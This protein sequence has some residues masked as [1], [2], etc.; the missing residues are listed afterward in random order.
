[1]KL[2]SVLPIISFVFLVNGVCV[3]D[4]RD[5]PIDVENAAHIEL[6]ISLNTGATAVTLGWSP[7]GVTLAVATEEKVLV[8]DARDWGGAAHELTTAQVISLIFSPDGQS[9]ATSSNFS[10]DG[11][12]IWDMQTGAQLVSFKDELP[13]MMGNVPAVAMSFS[14]DGKLLATQHYQEFRGIIYDPWVRL[15]DAHTGELLAKIDGGGTTITFNPDGQS[16]AATTRGTVRVWNLERILSSGPDDVLLEDLVL[17][18]NTILAFSD[19]SNQ[20]AYLRDGEIQIWDIATEQIINRPDIDKG[21]C[22]AKVPFPI[23]VNQ[24][25]TEQ[26]SVQLWD[27]CQNQLLTTLDN[28]TDVITGTAFNPDK[29]LLAT[30]SQDGTVRLWGLSC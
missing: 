23:V 27:G 14:P 13:N 29:T 28:Y 5:L 18:G 19:D 24:Y 30:T 1:M 6:L 8:Y 7:D 21:L 16:L 2:A 17:N 25:Q 12:V 10:G 4:T 9:I 26:Y 11:I 22:V 20:L 3:E 15:W